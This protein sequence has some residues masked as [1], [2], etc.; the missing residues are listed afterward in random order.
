MAIKTHTPPTGS[1]IPLRVRG[2][3]FRLSLDDTEGAAV[4]TYV[5]CDSE[6]PIGDSDD[7]LEHAELEECACP[8]GGEEFKI[9]VGA[10]LS[11]G[12]ED[13][14]WLYVGCRCPRAG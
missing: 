3:R 7:Y 2:Q 12:S 1:P 4:R 6:H 5:G 13:I 10:S 11:K 9:T 14:R 8:C